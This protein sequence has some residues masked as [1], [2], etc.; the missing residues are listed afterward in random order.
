MGPAAGKGLGHLRHERSEERGGPVLMSKRE[1]ATRGG[2]QGER[3]WS[4]QGAVP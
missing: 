4:L 2:G 3:A 1:G